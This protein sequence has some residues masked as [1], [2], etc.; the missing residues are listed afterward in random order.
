[1][2]FPVNHIV[3]CRGTFSIFNTFSL[4][5][6]LVP[7][8][9]FLFMTAY[10]MPWQSWFKPQSINIP[11]IGKVCFW[12]IAFRCLTSIRLPNIRT[13]Q[14]EYQTNEKLRKILVVR[15][16]GTINEA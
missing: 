14:M 15:M 3:V 6:I 2:S 12:T 11:C 9:F 4:L 16:Q 8:R 7:L 13:I 5:R 1:M 10:P